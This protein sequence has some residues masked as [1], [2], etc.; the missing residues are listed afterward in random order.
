MTNYNRIIKKSSV[1]LC[2]FIC[3][4]SFA[5]YAT[6]ITITD[7]NNTELQKRMELNASYLLTTIN[8]AFFNN[9]TPELN[10]TNINPTAISPILALWE[11]S[12]FRCYETQIITKAAIVPGGGYEIRNIPLFIKEADSTNQYQEAVI[13]FDSKGKIVD[14]RIGL[15][16]QQVIRI[17]KI[18]ISEKEYRRRQ[19]ILNFIESY[20][21]AYNRKDIDFL[22]KIFSV[23]A[24]VVKI[25]L[26]IDVV[27]YNVPYEKIINTKLI[28]PDTAKGKSQK[29]S[30]ETIRYMKLTKSGYLSS[31][32][33]YVFEKNNYINIR[34]DEIEIDQ[35]PKYSEIY[36]VTLK[37]IWNTT[38]YSDAG[39]LFLMIDFTDEEKP[40]ILV[41]TWQPEKVNNESLKKEELLKL[42]DF[43]IIR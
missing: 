27:V 25:K 10:V 32:R 34:F 36:G 31:L 28:I 29:V 42:S 6:T 39:Y 26:P 15:E 35:H 24:L 4:N 17:L 8:N 23:D 38:Y 40:I 20:R 16:E 3:T 30:Y 7:V 5:Q 11:T 19:I 9:K 2:M 37:Q 22:N 12:I 21:T 13:N 1:L 43:D 41:R 14:L 18:N 33:K